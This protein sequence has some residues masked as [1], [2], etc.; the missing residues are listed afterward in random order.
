[1]ILKN[2]KHVEVRPGDVLVWAT[3]PVNDVR[4]RY[5]LVVSVHVTGEFVYFWSLELSTLNLWR[6]SSAYKRTPLTPDI[7]RVKP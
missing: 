6:S 4:P 5:D 7:L 3:D 2:L 1:M